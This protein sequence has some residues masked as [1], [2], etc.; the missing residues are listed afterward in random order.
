MSREGRS[1][2]EIGCLERFAE[3][4]VALIHSG[5]AK[6]DSLYL[7]GSGK[8]MEGTKKGK[9][10]IWTFLGKVALFCSVL[11]GMFFLVNWLMSVNIENAEELQYAELFEPDVSA[12]VVIFGTSRAAQGIDPG[13]FPASLASRTYNFALQGCPPTHYRDGY[14]RFFKKH[15]P[16]PRIAI[17]E[18]E[19][20][21]WGNLPMRRRLEVDSEYWP[22]DVFFQQLTHPEGLSRA[23]MIKHRFPTLKDQE[24]LPHIFFRKRDYAPYHKESFNL[25]YLPYTLPVSEERMVDTLD[26]HGSYRDIIA[27]G[28]WVEELRADGT[29]VI[30]V[31]TPDLV[32]ARFYDRYEERQIGMNVLAK[33]WKVPFLNYLELPQSRGLVRQSELYGDWVHLNREG[34]RVFSAQLGKDLDSLIVEK[35]P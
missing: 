3:G 29:E 2:V 8:C 6:Q 26:L 16:Q 12:E 31:Q 10:G 7:S 17:I 20:T 18:V 25:G 35:F 27:L 14:H 21:A 9:N 33:Q 24:D 23:S 28:E 32:S 4:W 19:W 15:Y 13:L 5:G 30:F 1:V 11:V 34:S 22:W